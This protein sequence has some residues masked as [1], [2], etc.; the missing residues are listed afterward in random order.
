MARSVM[1]PAACLR[2]RVLLSSSIVTATLK[3]L[4][5][6]LSLLACL[7]TAQ[8]QP[9]GKVPFD[10]A[11]AEALLAPGQASLIGRVYAITT[12]RKPLIEF[13]QKRKYGNNL[14]VYLVPLTRHVQS[15]TEGV[16]AKQL[17]YVVM[18]KL[19][20]T[21]E[22]WS[23]RV[24]T[25]EEGNFRFRALKPGKYLLLVTIPYRTEAYNHEYQGE[26][27]TTTYVNNIP[28]GFSTESIYKDGPVHEIDLEHYI[29]RVVTVEAGEP[30]TDL[31][32][33]D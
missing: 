23:A 27:T 13:F 1:D 16:S 9:A 12:A 2:S 21:A 4:T 33:F 3:K 31:G 32:T 14:M 19:D 24:M 7:A 6:G 26:M 5:L 10:A 28:I 15:V 22:V 17:F 11:E 30:V 8:A 20:P 25:D 18:S 29:V